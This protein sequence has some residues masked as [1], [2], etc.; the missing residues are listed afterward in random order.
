MRI[1]IVQSVSNE[2]MRR[3]EKHPMIGPN[4]EKLTNKFKITSFFTMRSIN[5]S[6]V[7]G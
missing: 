1:E 7:K 5:E 3:I 6:D 2:E 4:F